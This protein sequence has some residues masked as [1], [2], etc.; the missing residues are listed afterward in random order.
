ME[1]FRERT[2][3][4]MAAQAKRLATF[5]TFPHPEGGWTYQ[6]SFDAQAEWA[7]AWAMSRDFVRHAGSRNK[8]PLIVVSCFKEEL[9]DDI[10]EQFIVEPQT[11]ELWN[12]H[13][14]AKPTKGAPR[15]SS[16][17]PRARSAVKGA[18]QLVHAICDKLDAEGKFDRKVA[19]Q[20]AEAEGVNRSTANTQVYRW[21]KL[22]DK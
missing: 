12:A 8:R 11:P 5:D 9:D 2:T 19:V 21:R 17:E 1:Q 14:P 22:H 18:V 4:I 7:A 10:P 15:V 3:A 6:P 20:Q 16:G 13:N